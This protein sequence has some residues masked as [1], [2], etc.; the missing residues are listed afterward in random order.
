MVRFR[1]VLFKKNFFSLWSGQIVSEFGD[2]LNQM[3]LIALVYSKQ[4]GSV[5][6][7]AKLLFFIVI[8]VFVI[9]PVAG[10][11]VDRWDRKRVMII[12]D[13][14]RGVFVLIIPLFVYLNMM[15]V[16][17]ILVFLIFSATRFFLP[18]KMAFIP[19]IVS[20]EKLMVANS[21]SNTTRMIATILGFGLAG[22]IIKWIGHMWGFYLDGLSYFIS[23]GFIALITPKEK[24]KD[25]REEIKMTKEIIGKSIRKNL[26]SEII[27]GVRHMFKK[28]KMKV[29]TSTLF[30]LMAGA[31][32]VFCVVIVFIQKAFGS[33]TGDLGILGVFLGAG[34]FLGTL[35]Y[36]KFG[37]NFSKIRAMFISFALCGITINLF[38]IY[39][40]GQPRL[41]VGGLLIALVGMAVAPIFICANTLIHILVPDEVRGRIFSSMEALIHLSFLIFM[42]LTAYLSKYIPA[43]TILIAS[44]IICIVVGV[45]GQMFVREEN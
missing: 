22:L 40:S 5:M 13:I 27:E 42:L 33:I 18:S 34:L 21:L 28:D 23:A 9:G 32:S 7:M 20:K 45:V 19:A 30:L 1:D 3:A 24:L 6:A 10:V 8:P 26:W 36:G 41:Y 39:A 12:A 2:R 25:V 15:P 44:G 4:P 37:Q 31:G 43:L 14:A 29:V 17:Y 35:L 16:V 38:S 11:Y